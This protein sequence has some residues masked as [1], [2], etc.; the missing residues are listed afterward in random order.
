L[1]AFDNAMQN[2]VQITGCSLTP[3]VDSTTNTIEPADFTVDY[4]TV[5]DPGGT[6]DITVSG[7]IADSVPNGVYAATLT[8]SG[9]AGVSASV[10][11]VEVARSACCGLMTSGYTGNTNCSVD[12][13]INLA[14]ITRLID[15]VYISQ[16]V[17][18]CEAN[19]DINGDAAGPNLADITKLIDHVYVSHNP[20]APCP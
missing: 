6:G 4:P 18:C 5:V 11:L 15:R 7:F 20:T 2:Q 16:T 13:S 9:D 19:G 1:A 8:V 10:I 12:G 14:D 3:F 17:L